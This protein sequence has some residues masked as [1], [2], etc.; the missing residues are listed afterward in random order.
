MDKNSQHRDP[1]NLS[2]IGLIKGR[3]SRAPPQRAVK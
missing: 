1:A 2:V 3:G